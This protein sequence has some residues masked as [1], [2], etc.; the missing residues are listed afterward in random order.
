MG[1]VKTFLLDDVTSDGREWFAFL[2][3]VFHHTVRIVDSEIKGQ[4]IRP[5][6]HGIVVEELWCTE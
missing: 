6:V 1:N 2:D 4:R 5:S 3:E